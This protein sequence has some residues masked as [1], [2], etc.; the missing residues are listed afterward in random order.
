MSGS[1]EDIPGA[2]QELGRLGGAGLIAF[3]RALSGLPGQ[4]T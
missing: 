3:P 2:S 1:S 4:P